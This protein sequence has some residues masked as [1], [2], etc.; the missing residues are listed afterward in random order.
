MATKTATNFILITINFNRI[1]NLKKK[2]KPIAGGDQW[3]EEKH[4]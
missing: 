4:K 3:A 2:K 1:N